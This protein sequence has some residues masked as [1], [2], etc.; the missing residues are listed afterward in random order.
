[1]EKC[2]QKIMRRVQKR[3]E[4]KKGWSHVKKLQ[5]EQEQTDS[6]REALSK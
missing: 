3:E 6:R 5:R 1:M 2:G 4:R